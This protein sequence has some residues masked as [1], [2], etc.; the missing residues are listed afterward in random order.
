[1]A[2]T[3]S[4]TADTVTT[5]T[6]ATVA[7]TATT[8][9]ASGPPTTMSS[10]AMLTNLMTRTMQTTMNSSLREIYQTMQQ[11]FQ[12]MLEHQNQQSRTVMCL[13]PAATSAMPPL[14]GTNPQPADSEVL[15]TQS[16]LPRTMSISAS[17]A[18]PS[19]AWGPQPMAAGTVPAGPPPAAAWMAPASSTWSMPEAPPP[20]AAVPPPAAWA[21]PAVQ[22]PSGGG[23]ASSSMRI[24]GPVT[25]QSGMPWGT[26]GCM[27]PPSAIAGVP[28]FTVAGPAPQEH[29]LQQTCII[30]ILLEWP[31]RGPKHRDL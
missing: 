31:Q 24:T 30:L 6:M 7:G 14:A 17:A 4:V 29:I 25:S 8:S 3:T 15:G 2:T 19:A 12:A 21:V 28:I 23:S 11:G 26:I 13:T 9:M 1:M 20:V 5:G 18:T 10:I 16:A 22:H 27:P